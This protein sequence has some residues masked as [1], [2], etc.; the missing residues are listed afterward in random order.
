MKISEFTHSLEQQLANGNTEYVCKSLQTFLKNKDESLYQQVLLLSSQYSDFKRNKSLGLEND[1]QSLNRINNALIGLCADIKKDYDNQ[2]ID[3]QTERE[4][5][6]VVSEFQNQLKPKAPSKESS[7][8]FLVPV[9]G[10]L[11]A[12]ALIWWV[13]SNVSGNTPSEKD[14]TKMTLPKT[15]N[16]AT[17]P[18]DLPTI[19]EGSMDLS[20]LQATFLD[21]KIHIQDIEIF[22]TRYYQTSGLS[23]LV[24]NGKFY[25]PRGSTGG[26]L[27]N[28]DYFTLIVDG[29]PMDTKNDNLTVDT[30][31]GINNYLVSGNAHQVFQIIY[32]IPASAKSVSLK[33]TNGGNST[34]PIDLNK[35]IPP[36]ADRPKFVN[37]SQE[38]DFNL[39]RNFGGG[40][41]LVS[42]KALPFDDNFITV[43][44]RVAKLPMNADLFNYC[45]RIVTDRGERIIG[46]EITKTKTISDRKN[47]IENQY[48][49]FVPRTVRTSELTIGNC[50]IGQEPFKVLLPL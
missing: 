10:G 15:E 24:F 27:L 29:Q 50:E 11:L 9:L 5:K 47:R 4:L 41:E 2:T 48:E 20:K 22:K 32:D 18:S 21:V 19:T 44:A 6:K 38:I 8:G 26:C 35:T 3:S 1:L 16:N 13:Y 23:R 34:I 45:I 49:F 39:A 40:Y 7:S 30:P 36:I 12:F 31:D 17:K 46:P 43:I 42:V 33:I 37:L 14:N 28:K 25:C